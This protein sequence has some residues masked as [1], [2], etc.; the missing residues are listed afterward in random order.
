M[1]V[2][3]PLMRADVPEP[4]SQ[5]KPRGADELW[6]FKQENKTRQSANFEHYPGSFG[7]CDVPDE[8]GVSIETTLMYFPSI[9]TKLLNLDRCDADFK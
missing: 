9:D 5:L 7:P 4:I 6:D 3:R 8:R 1:I 2:G